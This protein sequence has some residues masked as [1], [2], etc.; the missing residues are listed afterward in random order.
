MNWPV[1]K[2]A[3]LA[4]VSDISGVPLD[5]V[6]W[7]G[8]P[9]A[10]SMLVGT[11]IVMRIN[12]IISVGDDETRLSPSANL[13]NNQL[14]NQCGQRQFTWSIMVETQQTTAT[15]SADVIMD[16]IRVRMGRP[17][18]LVRLREVGVAFNNVAG[19][20][21]DDALMSGR[22][23]S[24]A[25]TDFYMNAVENDT[26]DSVEAGQWIEEAIIDS[27]TFND[28]GGPISPQLHID[29]DTRS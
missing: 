5:S 19:T 29:V 10:R 3:M 2:A 28:A 21:S 23:A 16:R 22:T 12:S 4:V 14:A 9:Q 24:W 13:S 7:R 18:T 26:D 6:V 25:M 15:D 27:D 11:R 17:T 20:A 1:K 8:S